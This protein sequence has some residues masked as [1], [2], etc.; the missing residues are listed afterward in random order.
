MKD[1]DRA[2]V[3]SAEAA[4]LVAAWYARGCRPL[5]DRVGSL[6]FWFDGATFEITVDLE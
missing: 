6:V 3:A 2:F 5:V 1:L 4:P